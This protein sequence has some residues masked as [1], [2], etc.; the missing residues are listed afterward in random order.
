MGLGWAGLESLDGSR[1]EMGFHWM[2]WLDSG[3]RGRGGA[4]PLL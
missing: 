2:S 4:P 3:G 1:A